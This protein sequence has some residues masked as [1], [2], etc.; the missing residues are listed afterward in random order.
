MDRLE[1]YGKK[2][3][4]VGYKNLPFPAAWVVTLEILEQSFASDDGTLWRGDKIRQMIPHVV[5]Q[6]PSA[7]SSPSRVETLQRCLNALG[8]ICT[9]DSDDD[10]LKRLQLAI[11]MHTRSEENAIKLC[12]LGCAR[13][14]WEDSNAGERLAGN[15][16]SSPSHSFLLRRYFVGF[17]N[18]TATFIAECAEDD[19]D[20]VA[21]SARS[22][23]RAV[24]AVSGSLEAVLS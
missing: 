4:Q 15:I 10:L 18:D 22:L 14:L 6:V 16:S 24:E 1:A 13:S 8:G 11:L 17:A 12:A 21:K 23:R 2:V 7:S 5:A 3:K 20:E 9:S 19:H